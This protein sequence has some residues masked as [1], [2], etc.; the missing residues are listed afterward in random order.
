MSYQSH[1]GVVVTRRGLTVELGSGEWRRIGD[2]FARDHHVFLR[3]FLGD[4]VLS[5]VNSRLARGSFRKRIEDGRE[6]ERT[7]DD[8]RLIALYLVA[9]NDPALFAAIAR[10]TGCDAIGCFTGRVHLRGPRA[11][12]GH[13]Y[14]W[15]SDATDH[16]LIGLTINLGDKPYEGGVLEIRRRDTDVVIA[17]ASNPT[18]GD[19]VIF[20]ISEELEHHVTPVTTGG[21]RVVLAGWFRREPDFWREALSAPPAVDGTNRPP[22][23]S[24]R[25]AI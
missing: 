12:G 16:R 15:H 6:I 20:R 10:L 19:A 8:P 24:Q 17:R 25:T 13:Y 23:A 14:P 5:I 1:A 4:D 7:L 2:A 3:G 21:P 22:T 9:L 11:D 18:P